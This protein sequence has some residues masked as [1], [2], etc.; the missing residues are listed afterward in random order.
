[1]MGD[2]LSFLSSPATDF[3]WG[4]EIF[5]IKVLSLPACMGFSCFWFLGRWKKHGAVL[6]GGDLFY[7]LKN[8]LIFKCFHYGLFYFIFIFE[9]SAFACLYKWTVHRFGCN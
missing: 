2:L 7:L 1:M 5:V 6:G 8:L 9:F 4:S 3:F